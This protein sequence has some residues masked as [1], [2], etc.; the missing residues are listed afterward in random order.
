VAELSTLGIVH[1][2]STHDIF[3]LVF[4]WV[5]ALVLGGFGWL[6]IFHNFGVVYVWL[7]RHKHHSWIPLV[8]G[9]FA[10]VGMAFCPL[11]QV[12]RFA[13]WPLF[14]DGGYCISV[15]T[16]GGLMELYAWRTRKRKHGT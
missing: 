3:I 14:I 16:I 4:R 8:G 5:L 7:V 15:L 11:P 2:M 1:A 12:Q 6:L 9:F 10:L 13:F